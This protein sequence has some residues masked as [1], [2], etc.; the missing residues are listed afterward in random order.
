MFHC[1]MN[2]SERR[3]DSIYTIVVF[4]LSVS[5]FLKIG[6]FQPEP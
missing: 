3:L 6:C 2:E 5:R 1:M 4:S